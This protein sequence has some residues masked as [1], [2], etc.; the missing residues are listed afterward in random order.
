MDTF[1]EDRYLVFL[2]VE[3]GEAE[4]RACDEEPLADC[5]SYEEAREVRQQYH[6]SGRDCV[7]RYVGPT[8]GGD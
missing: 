1:L 3:R 6:Q 2:R 4:R 5:A 7:I 8:G